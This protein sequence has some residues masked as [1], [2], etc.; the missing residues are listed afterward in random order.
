MVTLPST[1]FSYT[2]RMQKPTRKVLVVLLLLYGVASLIHFI[3][4]AEFLADYPNLPSSWSR[5]GVYL[6]WAGMT[7]VGFLGWLVFRS[8]FHRTGLVILAVYA[9]MGIDSLGHYVLAPVSA[10]SVAMNTTILLE[11]GAAILL[12]VESV[13]LFTLRALGRTLHVLAD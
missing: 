13:R 8:G 4:N 12:F 9:I 6:A 1:T 3:H 7:A 2:T 11:V 10:H 5:T